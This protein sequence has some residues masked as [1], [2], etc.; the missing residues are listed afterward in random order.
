MKINKCDIRIYEHI[1]IILETVTAQ[2]F[3]GYQQFPSE[4]DLN[5]NLKIKSP[6]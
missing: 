6:I 3:Q 2:L 1:H 4:T 5:I